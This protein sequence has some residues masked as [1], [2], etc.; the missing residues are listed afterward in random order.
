MVAKEAFEFDDGDIDM[1]SMHPLWEEY[2]F[3]S[4]DSEHKFFYFNPYSGELS[5][6]FPEAN[7]QERG[8]ILADGKS[9]I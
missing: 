7:S 9:S 3:P 6:E 8:G 2:V 5:L 1:R 4:T